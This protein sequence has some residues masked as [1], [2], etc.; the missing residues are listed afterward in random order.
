MYAE[1]HKSPADS[2]VVR[3]LKQ[4]GY[5]VYV[6]AFVVLRSRHPKCL[7]G[8]RP[9]AD[10]VTC[11]LRPY[12]EQNILAVPMERAAEFNPERLP[13]MKAMRQVA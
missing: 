11:G 6:H 12:K 2:P 4:L 3:L 8:N 10:T 9:M 5:A 1:E 13:S 7:K